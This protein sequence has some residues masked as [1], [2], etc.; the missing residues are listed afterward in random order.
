MTVVGD[1][2]APLWR[3]RVGGLRFEGTAMGVS[4][5]G[6]LCSSVKS[7]YEAKS[8]TSV[9]CGEAEGALRGVLK[10]D[11]KGWVSTR[12]V[13]MRRRFLAGD[14]DIPWADSED[15]II[16]SGSGSSEVSSSSSETSIAAASEVH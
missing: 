9:S 8:G 6:T 12:G 16:C 14:G 1:G 7:L 2:R 15:S 3:S 10:G 11:R 13:P 4:T 5:G